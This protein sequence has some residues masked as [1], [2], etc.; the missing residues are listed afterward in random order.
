MRVEVEEDSISTGSSLCR[1]L[2]GS[3]E[4]WDEEIEDCTRFKCCIA[5]RGY[6]TIDPAITGIT[7]VGVV[8]TITFPTPEETVEDYKAKGYTY[9]VVLLK[10]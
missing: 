1:L 2:V 4:D 7:I 3:I 8:E 6:Y 9:K 5:Y 10:E